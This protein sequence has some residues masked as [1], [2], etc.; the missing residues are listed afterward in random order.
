MVRK[1]SG[2]NQLRAAIDTATKATRKLEEAAENELDKG[3]TWLAGVRAD[4]EADGC[5]IRTFE[6]NSYGV[7]LGYVDAGWCAVFPRTCVY[8][9]VWEPGRIPTGPGTDGSPPC[10]PASMPIG[11]YS[12]IPIPIPRSVDTV[13]RR[14]LTRVGVYDGEATIEAWTWSLIVATDDHEPPMRMRRATGQSIDGQ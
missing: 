14:T 4:L 6:T 1:T 2:R 10:A 3:R 5:E 13:S 7:P 9:A 12:P 8:L 11:T